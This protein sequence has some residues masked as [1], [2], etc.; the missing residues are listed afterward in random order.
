M[1]ESSE[2]D[3]QLERWKANIRQNELFRQELF[4][5]VLHSDRAA[6]D[7]GLTTLRTAILIN[8]GAVVALLAFVGQLWDRHAD[9]LLAVLE[10]ARWFV[11]GLVLAGVA[12]CIAY[13]YQSFV[14]ME[15][16]R[17]L[18]QLSEGTY[19]LSSRGAWPWLILTTAVVM[20]LF[21]FGSYAFFV[22][23][24]LEVVSALGQWQP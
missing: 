22:W 6:I 9:R 18:N 2:S 3:R 20:V 7:I 10:G 24:V 8:G 17:W 16:Q 14:T 21:I 13:L 4:E 19:A 11:F 5:G 15:H 12:A 1:A 23:G